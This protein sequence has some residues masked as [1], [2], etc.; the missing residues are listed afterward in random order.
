[1]ALEQFQ[2]QDQTPAQEP[3]VSA[4]PASQSDSELDQYT[5]S[6][7]KNL[8]DKRVAYDA[9]LQKM[10][11]TFQERQKGLNYDPKLLGMA[12]GLL[13]DTPFFGVAAGRGFKGY[14]EADEAQRKQ[15]IENMKLENELRGLQLTDAEK[16]YLLQQKMLGQKE[17]GKLFSGQG[18]NVA[19]TSSGKADVS[20][21]SDANQLINNAMRTGNRITKE[22]VAKIK[23][24]DK[25]L[26]ETAQKL[27]EDQQKEIETSYKG[28]ESREI[29]VP[30]IGTQ[31]LTANQALVVSKITNSPQYQSLPAYAKDAGPDGLSQESVMRELYGRFGTGEVKPVSKVTEKPSTTGEGATTTPSTTREEV[32]PME[33]ASELAN[34]RD[35]EKQVGI[36]S[37]KE[38]IK[39]EQNFYNAADTAQQRR[40]SSNNVER[41]AKANPKFFDT[42]QNPN[43][44][45]TVGRLIN[46]GVSTPWG[47]ISIDAKDASA[48]LGNLMDDAGVTSLLGWD[49]TNIK[50]QDREAYAM[51]LR[52]L[53]IM[54]V[55]QRR[56]AN[57]VGQ[58]SISDYEQRLFASTTFMKDDDSRVQ[59]LKAKMIRAQAEMDEGLAKLL[60]QWKEKNPNKPVTSFLYSSLEF[61]QFKKNYEDKLEKIRNANADLFGEAEQNLNLD[62]NPPTP[63]SKPGSLFSQLQEEKNRRQGVQ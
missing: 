59:Q 30:F 54:Q 7:L 61:Q 45:D 11:N 55:A 44:R 3:V 46:S 50:K 47:S 53:A 18:S 22:Q 56:S 29:G 26:G 25:E 39:R 24:Y 21:I 57:A 63:Q 6:A 32:P 16:D 23:Y 27:Y 20:N 41:I 38:S 36:E 62:R 49:K 40:I 42:L 12:E 4:P 5:T 14:R 8:H 48:A 17:F 9:H 34:R 51:F 2:N 13:S 43:V 37:G 19:T 1:M 58:G 10:I 35:I 52:D 31:K 28:T 15:E 60:T 33:T